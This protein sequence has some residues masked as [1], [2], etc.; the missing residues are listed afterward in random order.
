MT[1]PTNQE[2]ERKQKVI[3]TDLLNVSFPRTNSLFKTCLH[4]TTMHNARAEKD[5]VRHSMAAS[6]SS[7]GRSQG[8]YSRRAVAVHFPLVRT[9][10]LFSPSSTIFGIS[11]FRIVQNYAMN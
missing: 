11:M 4:H 1:S 9:M 10:I 6:C 2:E 3:Q 7:R 5:E 8:E